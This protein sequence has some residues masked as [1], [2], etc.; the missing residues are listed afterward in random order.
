VI[1]DHE[2]P[3]FQD[4]NNV[5]VQRCF[6]AYEFAKNYVA[7][8]VA[9]DIGCATGYGTVALAETAERIVGLDYSEPTISQNIEDYRDKP[10]MS[11]KVCNIPP[12]PL[13]DES[14][15]VVT[16]FQFI[17]HIEN[18]KGFVKD[19]FRVL[20][21]GG[22]FI[23]TTVNAKKSIARNPYHIFEYTF[24]DMRKEVADVFENFEL[25]GL[26]GN[27]T[28]NKYYEDNA[29]WVKRVMMLDP[30]GLHKLLPGG[31]L[32]KPYNYLTTKMRES[33]KDSN[34][35]TLKITTKDFAL[36]DQNLD[37]CWDIFMIA[38]KK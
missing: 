22:V 35:D 11:F 38:H 21:P 3:S 23:C 30:L 13:E 15:D 25:K 18:R 31:L 37:E 1:Y 16:A 29:R 14:V 6:Y 7:G 32:R 9:A 26:N 10:N 28:V 8:K 2:R 24:D 17:E 5:T 12:I 36:Q 33:L 34:Q 20:K 27:A 4:S 19:V